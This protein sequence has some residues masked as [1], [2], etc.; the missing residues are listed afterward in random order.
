MTTKV[1]MT[2]K[3]ITMTTKVTIKDYSDNNNGHND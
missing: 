2:K 1:T 3:K